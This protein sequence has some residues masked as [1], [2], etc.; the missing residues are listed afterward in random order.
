MI[1]VVTA[2]QELFEN[3]LY[4]IISVKD[5]LKLL[6]ECKLLQFD[7]ETTGRLNLI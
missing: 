7:S 3:P 2:K 6:N 4:T 5:S 1:Y